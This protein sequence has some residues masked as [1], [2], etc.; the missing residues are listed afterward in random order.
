MKISQAA[1]LFLISCATYVSA[2]SVP[3]FRYALERWVPDDYQATIRCQGPMPK[4]LR[5]AVDNLRESGLNLRVIVDHNKP[6]AIP[7]TKC[8]IR[9][10]FPPSCQIDKPLWVDALTT[11]SI[12][13]ITHS[14]LRQQISN[15][16]VNGGS[17]VWLLLKSGI[18]AKDAAAEKTLRTELKICQ[19]SIKL[20]KIDSADAAIIQ[21]E[22]AIPLKIEFPLLVIDRQAPQETILINTLLNGIPELLTTNIPAAFPICGAAR[23]FPPLIGDQISP[24]HINMVCSFLTGECSCEI[25]GQNPGFDLLIAADWSG[26]GETCVYTETALPELSGVL[27]EKPASTNLSA[28]EKMTESQAENS[29]TAKVPIP[30]A[31]P[32]AAVAATL[33]MLLLIVLGGS[34]FMRHATQK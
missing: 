9:I 5:Q 3:V 4:N 17:I 13:T 2:C 20:P 30:H 16:I 22:G 14:P 6:P 19:E 8:E 15:K 7:G 24:D 18:P 31:S 32:L 26:S 21:N 10:S 1:S 25:K 33:G 11:N 12:K 23:A 27:P 28:P 29:A 34:I